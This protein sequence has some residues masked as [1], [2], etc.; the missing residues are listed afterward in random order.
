VT[1]IVPEML[2]QQVIICASPGF[3]MVRASRV[4]PRVT[5]RGCVPPGQVMRLHTAH[6]LDSFGSR[7]CRFNQ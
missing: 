1:L 2:G 4:T 3:A 5:F 7:Y 6:A